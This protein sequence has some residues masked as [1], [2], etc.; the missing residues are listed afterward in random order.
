MLYLFLAG[1]IVIAAVIVGACVTSAP[2]VEDDQERE[3]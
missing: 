2:Q 1:I 3:Q